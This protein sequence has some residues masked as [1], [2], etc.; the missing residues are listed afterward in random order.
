[1][2]N[3]Q[4]I[5]AEVCPYAQRSHMCLLEK[6]LEFERIE[7]DL[8]DKP[9]WFEKVSPYS[10]VPVLKHGEVR[11]YE[12][13]IVNEYLN[14]VFPD[15][16][17]LPRSAAARAEARTWIDFDNVKFLPA[18]YGVLLEQDPDQ[19]RQIAARIT[20]HFES[21]ESR[22]LGAA[23]TGP[24]WFDDFL[25]LV[26]LA[27]YPHFERLAALESY[28]GICI[29]DSCG[30]LREWLA[31]MRERP[32]AKATAHDDDYHIKAYASYADG[33]ASGTTA[34]DMRGN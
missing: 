34:Q 10:K 13:S 16:P 25:S 5:Q 18:F 31:A 28:R 9:A 1:M 21:F 33:T 26:D 2:S 14:E 3:L 11:V 24:Y 19:Q 4:L 22:A 27:V 29:P 30:K 7:I 8:H 12:S 20:D 6:G 23:W 17:L 32:S 15:P